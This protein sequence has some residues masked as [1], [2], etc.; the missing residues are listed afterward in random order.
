MV[1]FF[2]RYF[3][4][5]KKNP[6]T[7]GQRSYTPLAEWKFREFNELEHMFH[8]RLNMSYFFATRYLEQF[9]KVKTGHFATFV[10][11]VT[12]SIIAVLSIAALLDPEMFFSFEIAGDTS[13]ALW[14]TGLGAIWAV[15]SGSVPEPNG[16]FDP[17]QE[18][19]SVIQY[20][21]YGPP[22]WE[23]RLETN[24]VM[25][26]FCIIATPF[27]LGVSLPRCADQIID[28]FREFTVHVDGVGY[29]CSFAVFD[30][31]RGD[32]RNGGQAPVADA[33]DDYYSTKHGKMTASYYGFVDNRRGWGVVNDVPY[34]HQML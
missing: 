6:S 30:F 28:F 19:R 16:V 15:M 27:V 3:N 14:I 20:T 31:K 7:I 24:D 25:Q 21:H 5:Y 2:F 23:G 22:H 8:E 12:G 18:M 11:F 10:M 34:E 26:I 4:E 1:L 9:P 32:G 29:V 17:E 13:V 33:R